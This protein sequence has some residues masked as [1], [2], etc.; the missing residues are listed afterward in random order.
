MSVAPDDIA[1]FMIIRPELPVLRIGSG[2]MAVGKFVDKRHQPTM[3]EI[4]SSIGAKRRFWERLAEFLANNYRVKTDF[5][6]YGKNYGWALR[7][8]KAGK[9]LLSMY[10]GKGVFMVQIVLAATLA[11]ETF[12]LQLGKNVGNVLKSAR[13]F[14]EGRWLF[15]PI[16]SERDIEDVEKLLALKAQPLKNEQGV[17]GIPQIG[18]R[19]SRSSRHKRNKCRCEP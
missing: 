13:D 5:A 2:E 14:P 1:P 10:P 9:A 19:L 17:S 6:F 7:F 4:F 11:K 12:D 8:R 16:E 18:R 15:I 3:R